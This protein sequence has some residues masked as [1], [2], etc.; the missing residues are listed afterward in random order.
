VLGADPPAGRRW[1]VERG[2][3]LAER[4]RRLEPFNLLLVA[5]L[6][7]IRRKRPRH[8][9]LRQQPDI[10]TPTAASTMLSCCV[11]AWLYDNWGCPDAQAAG[12]SHNW[13]HDKWQPRNHLGWNR[14]DVT[15][16]P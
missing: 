4:L 10:A 15:P 5:P 11:E 13:Q 14:F 2:A 6:N 9:D 1:L 12:L 3:W 7:A 8:L 16:E